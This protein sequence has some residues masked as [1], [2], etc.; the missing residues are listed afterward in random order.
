MILPFSLSSTCVE[1][2]LI[3]PTLPFVLQGSLSALAVVGWRLSSSEVVAIKIVHIALFLEATILPLSLVLLPGWDHISCIIFPNI[4]IIP[5][6]YWN[7]G[8]LLNQV[9][10]WILFDRYSGLTWL[11]FLHGQMRVFRMILKHRSECRFKLEN[12]F[13][14]RNLPHFVCEHRF[15]WK[16]LWLLFFISRLLAFELQFL[17]D[18]LLLWDCNQLLTLILFRKYSGRSWIFIEQS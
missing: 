2:W 14:M 18:S 1:R 4:D 9:C 17:F 16:S 6:G 13:Y 7:A 12:F 5:L 8:L 10:I 3:L 15:K 11:R